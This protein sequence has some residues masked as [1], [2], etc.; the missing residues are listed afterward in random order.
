MDPTWASDDP[1]PPPSPTFVGPGK[2]E[3]FVP[4]EWLERLSWWIQVACVPMPPDSDRNV[5]LPL[6]QLQ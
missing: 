4:Y 2:I 3:S 5:K 1:I 6:K